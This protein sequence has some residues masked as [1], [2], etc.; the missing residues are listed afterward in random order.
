LPPWRK[1]NPL[2]VRSTKKIEGSKESP[3][4]RNL[5]THDV[6]ETK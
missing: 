2:E 6:Q 1:E 3:S 5:R 4:R